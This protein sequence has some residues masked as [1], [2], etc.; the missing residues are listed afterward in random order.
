MDQS[1]SVFFHTNIDI[2]G[3]PTIFEDSPV[4]GQAAMNARDAQTFFGRGWDRKNKE[5]TDFLN[6][7]TTV[8][9]SDMFI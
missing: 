3:S 1:H 2:S 8:H 6:H 9:L 5:K 7:F 4:G